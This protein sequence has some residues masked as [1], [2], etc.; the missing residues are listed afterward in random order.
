MMFVEGSLRSGRY[1]YDWVLNL[2]EDDGYQ[3]KML[4]AHVAKLNDAG[5]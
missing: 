3:V 4:P 1:R 5:P 2:G